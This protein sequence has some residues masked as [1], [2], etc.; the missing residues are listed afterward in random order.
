MLARYVIAPVNRIITPQQKNLQHQDAISSEAQ[1]WLKLFWITRHV[2]IDQMLWILNE[3]GLEPT[4]KYNLATTK[5]FV[6]WVVEESPYGKKDKH[7][8]TGVT[9]LIFLEYARRMGCTN[10]F[11]TLCN[12]S[13]KHKLN[14][15]TI[16]R[17]ESDHLEFVEDWYGIGKGN[18]LKEEFKD[19]IEGKKDIDHKH[20]SQVY[21]G[22]PKGKTSK[23]SKRKRPPKTAT[24][25]GSEESGV[26]DAGKAAKRASTEPNDDEDKD[27]K[28][29]AKKSPPCQ[30]CLGLATAVLELDLNTADGETDALLTK[31]QNVLQ[32]NIPGLEEVNLTAEED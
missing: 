28:P 13:G 4:C 2:L 8:I 1:V 29:A 22:V 27:K 3:Y 7:G 12:T 20:L 17:V 15:K 25:K 6:D 19:I 24:D 11:S 21:D 23:A 30:H 14:G 10:L 32:T 18:K 26:A 5:A 31:I 9:Q 16:F